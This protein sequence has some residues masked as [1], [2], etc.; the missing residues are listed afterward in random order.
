MLSV[1]LCKLHVFSLHL[2]WFG[3]IYLKTEPC[4]DTVAGATRLSS[5]I[6]EVKARRTTSSRSP[7]II[8][9][10]RPT[11]ITR[12]TKILRESFTQ[13]PRLA[14]NCTLSTA[15]RAAGTTDSHFSAQ[16]PQSENAEKPKTSHSAPGLCRGV[17]WSFD[18]VGNLCLLTL[19]VLAPNWF[20]TYQ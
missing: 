12:E 15:S 17:V 20:L 14:L 18:S 10:E 2:V 8:Q 5:S 4:S 7:L 1:F 16:V 3:F 9:W 19:K 11:W 6:W 13:L